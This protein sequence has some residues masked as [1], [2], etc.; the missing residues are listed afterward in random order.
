MTPLTP[1]ERQR[2]ADRAVRIERVGAAVGT[3]LA[4]IVL[5]VLFSMVHFIV[6]YW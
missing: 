2:L 1:R 4:V 6:K 3:L 5:V